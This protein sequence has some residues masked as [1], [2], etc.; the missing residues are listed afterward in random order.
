[1]TK[2]YLMIT[3]FENHWDKVKQTS[4]T[5]NFISDEVKNNLIANETIFV[6][7]DSSANKRIL[8]V[9]E[10]RVSNITQN[11]AK[12]SF[13]VSIDREVRDHAKWSIDIKQPYWR[14][15]EEANETTSYYTIPH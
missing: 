12:I 7:I 13:D 4:Y 2:K 14:F 15:F 9:W 10:G 8:K 3:N 1:M 6:K 11:G 5:T